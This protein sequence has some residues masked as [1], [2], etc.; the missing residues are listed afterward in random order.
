MTNEYFLHPV[1]PTEAARVPFP[2]DLPR[3]DRAAYL[4]AP[5]AEAIATA[6]RVPLPLAAPAEAPIEAP[7]ETP[8]A[9]E[10][11]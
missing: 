3:A 5:P 10:E 8:P 11:D 9:T 2:A 1:S 4:A 6:E 7:L